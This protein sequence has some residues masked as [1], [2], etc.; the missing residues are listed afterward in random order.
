LPDA[1]RFLSI[2]QSSLLTYSYPAPA[3]TSGVPTIDWE[4][5]QTCSLLKFAAIAV[6]M[7]IRI[8]PLTLQ[9]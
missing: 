8:V 5:L 4:A 2:Q 1:E 7:L 6:A 3:R 9:P